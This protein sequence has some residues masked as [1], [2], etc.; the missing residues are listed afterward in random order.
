M[1]GRPPA[2]GYAALTF[3]DFV[4]H[5]AIRAPALTTNMHFRLDGPFA[6]DEV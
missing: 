3:D 5:D 4:V 6:T 1:S 2:G